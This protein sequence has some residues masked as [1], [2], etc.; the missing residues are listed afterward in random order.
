MPPGSFPGQVDTGP[1][2]ACGIVP[3][4]ACERE[5]EITRCLCGP[6]EEQVG[7]FVCCRDGV[8]VALDCQQAQYARDCDGNL[9]AYVDSGVD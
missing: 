5:G 2:R 4:S 1:P 6:F 3:G 9:A 7:R 8:A